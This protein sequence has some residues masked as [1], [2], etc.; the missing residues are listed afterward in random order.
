MN[1]DKKMPRPASRHLHQ[2]L[3][4]G[5]LTPEAGT[6]T[7][8]ESFSVIFCKVTET[9]VLE[10]MGSLRIEAPS[11]TRVIF[12]GFQSVVIALTI[13]GYVVTKDIRAVIP[14]AISIRIPVPV[15]VIAKTQADKNP[16][17][18]KDPSMEPAAA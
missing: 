12:A 8:F 5:Y 7:T 4:A 6:V 9:G 13:G 15:W 1:P 11:M 14:V 17:S 18:N 3:A 10:I 2:Q 16:G